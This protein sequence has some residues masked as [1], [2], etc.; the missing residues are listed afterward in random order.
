MISETIVIEGEIIPI[1]TTAPGSRNSTYF[2]T[3][4]PIKN[5]LHRE[6]IVNITRFNQLMVGIVLEDVGSYGYGDY[7]NIFVIREYT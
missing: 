7:I 2:F 6:D 1:T 5:F 3:E 4:R